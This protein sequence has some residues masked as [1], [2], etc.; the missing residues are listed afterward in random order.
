M[1]ATKRIERQSIASKLTKG[2]YGNFIDQRPGKIKY[3]KTTE[4]ENKI[5]IS[6]NEK[7]KENA[8][9]SRAETTSLLSSKCGSRA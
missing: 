4:I 3:K 1:I 8:M 6:L 7:L 5:N 9:V 2:K